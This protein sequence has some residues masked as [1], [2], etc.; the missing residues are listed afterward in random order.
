MGQTSRKV[1]R[2]GDIDILEVI[3]EDFEGNLIEQYY[4]VQGEKYNTLKDA[5]EAARKA[6]EE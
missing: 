5:M 3:R 6:G 1:A 4:Y 2:I